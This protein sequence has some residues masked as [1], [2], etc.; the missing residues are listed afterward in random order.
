MKV[1]RQLAAKRDFSTFRQAYGAVV[2]QLRLK[3]GFSRKTLAR[4][5]KVSESQLERIERGQGNPTITTLFNIAAALGTRTAR[6]FK[7]A[8]N[9]LH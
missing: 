1:P 9:H 4:K 5:S 7:Q 3:A 6:T 2:R 8:Q